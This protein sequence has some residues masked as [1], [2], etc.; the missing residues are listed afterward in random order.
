MSGRPFCYRVCCIV[1]CSLYQFNSLNQ[2]WRPFLYSAAILLPTVQSNHSH[3]ATVPVRRHWHTIF[4]S[5]WLAATLTGQLH[6]VQRG[7]LQTKHPV[8]FTVSYN[9]YIYIYIYSL[10]QFY[11]TYLLTPWS[12]V[13]L[14]KLTSKLCR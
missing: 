2:Q 5:K 8:V 1:L 6:T 4:C 3:S 9:I 13:L 10:T 14:E 12:R 7:H 11:Y